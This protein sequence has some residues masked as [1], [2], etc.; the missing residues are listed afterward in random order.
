MKNK[1]F[2]KLLA[3]GLC[4]TTLSSCSNKGPECVGC[5][6]ENKTQNTTESNTKESPVVKLDSGLS[7]EIIEKAADNAQKPTRG[8]EVIVHY[9]G[10]LDKNNGNGTTYEKG[11]KFDS[12]VDRGQ[13]FR[14]VVGIGQ[15]IAGWDQTLLDMKVGEKRLVSIPPHL[16]YGKNGAG[17]VIPPNA[18]LL[19]EVELRKIA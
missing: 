6:K 15:V 2:K 1:L 18:T 7:Y 10:W 14:F 4:C 3:V 12:S 13:E 17:N 9:T 19:F 5:D 16:A 11:T 8:Q